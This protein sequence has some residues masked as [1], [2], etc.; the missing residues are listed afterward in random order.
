M[1]LPECWPFI[2]LTL[3]KYNDNKSEL[4]DLVLTNLVRRNS[5]NRG[6]EQPVTSDLHSV[7]FSHLALWNPERANGL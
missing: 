7:I 6:L 3:L 1:A 5:S 2:Q 4:N